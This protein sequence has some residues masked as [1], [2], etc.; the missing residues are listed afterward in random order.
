MS[1]LARGPGKA[2]D[3]QQANAGKEPTPLRPHVVKAPGGDSM[4]YLARGPGGTPG[5][6]SKVHA[7]KEPTPQCMQIANDSGGEGMSPLTVSACRRDLMQF[8]TKPRHA[9]SKTSS[10][11]FPSTPQAAP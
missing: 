6:D 3:R 9:H 5:I 4:S 11:R 8:V 1:Y 10:S 2:G 7:S